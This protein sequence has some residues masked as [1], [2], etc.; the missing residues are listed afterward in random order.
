MINPQN[1]HQLEVK[2]LIVA[3]QMA[4]GI[5]KINTTV[6]QSIYLMCIAIEEF[7]KIVIYYS[8]NTLLLVAR[9][10]KQII[11][12]IRYWPVYVILNC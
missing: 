12:P 6:L 10:R 3:E 2:Y 8:Y 11:M 4:N 1:C 9:F 5:K 7:T